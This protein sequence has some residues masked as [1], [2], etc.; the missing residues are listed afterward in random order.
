MKVNQRSG[1][2]SAGE[3]AARGGRSSLLFGAVLVALVA[4]GVVSGCYSGCEGEE[5][6]FQCG[7]PLDGE[8]D[9]IRYC[10]DVG[11]VCVC[12]T[13]YCAEKDTTCA[14][15]YRYLGEPFGAPGCDEVAED[16]GDSGSGEFEASCPPCVKEAHLEWIVPEGS[17]QACSGEP[18]GGGGGDGGAGG[19][20]GSGGMGGSGGGMGGSGGGMGGSGG[21]G[22]A[23]GQMSS[24][25]GQ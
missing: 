9:V 1:V 4:G 10:A 16:A 11:E 5:Q 6:P 17:K 3:R 22:G 21:N 8:P 14:S 15:G 25:G 2:S 23:G 13:N 19:E 12:E 20:M 24:G 7:V 18:D